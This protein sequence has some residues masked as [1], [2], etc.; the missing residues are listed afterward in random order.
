VSAFESVIVGPGELAIDL[1][2]GWAQA[3]GLYG[4]YVIAS[5]ARAAELHLGAPER[6]LRSLTAE[7]LAPA[8]PGPAR[9]RVRTLKSGSAVSSVAVELVQSD[10]TVAHAVAVLGAPRHA[11]LERDFTPGPEN[12]PPWS[13][14]API[15]PGLPML[16]EF[17]A[18]FDVRNVGPAPFSGARE[19]TALG[20]VRLREGARA[21]PTHVA[22]LADVYWPAFLPCFDSPRPTATVTFALHLTGAT[23]SP[24]EPLVHRG[25]T[26][27][28]SDGY[29]VEI[30][31]LFTPA[32]AL[33][34]VNQQTFVII[35]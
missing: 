31:E 15:P 7:L 21:E 29:A 17:I 26:L 25:R 14:L 13:E 34:S 2:E 23:W 19:A 1:P 22:A 35:R 6:A 33:V 3:R 5:L 30:R 32:G 4:G 11:P 24:E 28:A 27:H 10:A 9:L 12:L 20:Y 8:L 18:Q 16:P